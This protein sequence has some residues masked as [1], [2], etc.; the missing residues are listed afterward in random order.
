[1]MQRERGADAGKRPSSDGMP[2]EFPFSCLRLMSSYTQQK[3]L[4]ASF[5]PLHLC[6]FKLFKK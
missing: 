6:P 5:V 4:T 2:F 3:C 1:M